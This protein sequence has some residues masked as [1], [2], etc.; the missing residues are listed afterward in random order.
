MRLKIRSDDDYSTLVD[1]K[2]RGGTRQV[3][4]RKEE[5]NSEIDPIV[6]NNYLFLKTL[7][8]LDFIPLD[9]IT[10]LVL[11]NSIKQ[12]LEQ[13]GIAY[14][15]AVIDHMCKMNG[16]SEREILTNC[17]LFEDSIYRLFGHGAIF[18]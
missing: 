4:S 13:V 12:S 6:N 11:Y 17:D 15:K 5:C 2:K 16:L 9:S 8:D 18:S 14:S 1:R 7:D 3:Y 10:E